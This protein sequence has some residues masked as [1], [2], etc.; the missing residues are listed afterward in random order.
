[1]ADVQP[2]P[3]AQG[4]MSGLDPLSGAGRLLLNFLPDAGGALYQRP[5]IQDFDDFPNDSIPNASPVIGMFEWRGYVLYVCE[6]RTIWALIAPGLVQALSDATAATQ[7]DGTGL[8]VWTYDQARVV[9]TGGGAPQKWEGVGLSSRLAPGQ[10]DPSGAPLALTHIAY[11]A[12]RFIG[13][14][15]SNAGYLQWTAPGQGNH[16]TWP[17]VGPYYSEAEAAPDPVVAV[18]ATTNEVFAFGTETTQ[19]YSPDPAIGFT[20][21]ASIEVGAAA[22]YSVIKTED[23]NFY[24]LDNNRRFVASNGRA[25]E[26]ISTPYI[27]KTVKNLSDISDCWGANMMVGGWDLIVWV[28]HV[29]RRA[30]YYD[31]V[32]KK[33]GEFDSLDSNGDSQSWIARS[34]FYWKERNVHLVGLSDGR[35]AEL[36]FDAATDDGDTILAISETGFQDRGSLNEKL[37]EVLRLQLRRGSTDPSET[38]PTVRVRYRNDLGAWKPALTFSIGAGQ[39]Q[40]VV[41]KR[42]LGKYRQRQWRLEWSGGNAFVLAG[43]TED[44]QTLEA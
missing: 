38:A 44:F 31:K 8:P 28:F 18:W 9:V 23:G 36:T 6:D 2:I 25:V 19:V 15:N 10:T 33:W 43:A 42:S 5:G 21:S 16:A 27:A 1:M 17:I 12:Q 26:V 37:C 3:F 11:S 24:W 35:I 30:F 29:E 41:G 20:V 13:N 22:A 39:Y 14:V 34:Y 32:T 4:Q 40:P 7:L